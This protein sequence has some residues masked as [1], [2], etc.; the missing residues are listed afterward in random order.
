MKLGKKVP[1]VFILMELD[2][3]MAREIG[4]SYFEA[5]LFDLC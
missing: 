5:P 4:G 2:G 1:K 3:K